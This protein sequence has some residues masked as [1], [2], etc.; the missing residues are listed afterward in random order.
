M[1][2]RSSANWTMAKQAAQQ[3]CTECDSF[4]SARL[5]SRTTTLMRTPELCGKY[6]EFC[7]WFDDRPTWR[8]EPRMSSHVRC[9]CHDLGINDIK[10]FIKCDLRTRWRRNMS[11]NAVVKL[12]VIQYGWAANRAAVNFW[13]LNQI[14]II[15]HSC[16]ICF[17]PRR[18]TDNVFGILV[19]F[20][21]HHFVAQTICLS[22]LQWICTHQLEICNENIAFPWLIV[23]H[24]I[25]V[26]CTTI[27]YAFSSSL[28]TDCCLSSFREQAKN[29]YHINWI[30]PGPT[31]HE[32]L[33][34]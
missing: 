19:L 20:L 4:G 10:A 6:L 1:R 13:R 27:S 16:E 18:P 3:M 29:D 2:W 33:N 23:M 21:S 25:Y 24:V 34:Y 8:T 14:S 5:C 28:S 9:T 26:I 22:S 17:H 31:V 7:W 12:A 30:S 11:Q 32:W 15:W